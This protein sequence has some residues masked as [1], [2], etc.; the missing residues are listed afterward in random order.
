MQ[1]RLAEMQAE[2][3]ALRTASQALPPHTPERQTDSAR[4]S[5][6]PSFL[7]ISHSRRDPG[8]L[9]AARMF[10]YAL[11][12]AVDSIQQQPFCKSCYTGPSG[13]A[14]SVPSVDL[15]FDK[16]EMSVMGGAGWG[17]ELAGA[18]VRTPH[19]LLAHLTPI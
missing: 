11:R 13:Q 4:D 16:E 19:L 3:T 14:Q 2:I 7:F 10:A 5:D 9:N 17:E 15:W 18:Q 8:A 12:H 6:S 1:A